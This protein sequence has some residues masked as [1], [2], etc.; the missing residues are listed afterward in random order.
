MT[1][2]KIIGISLLIFL[3]IAAGIF[4]GV[5]AGYMGGLPKLSAYKDLGHDQ[6]SKVYSA[7]GTVIATF[8]AE[9]N[10]EIIPLNEIPKNVQNAVIDMEDERFYKHHGVDLKAIIRA[11]YAN[12]RSREVSE[13]ASTITQQYV[14]NS[15]I[16]P[17]VT[18]SRK[19]K[20]AAL[21]YQLEQKYSKDK[22][23]EMY[24]NTIYFGQGCYGV[25]TASENF[26]HKKAKDL[27]LGESSLLAGL[28]GAPNLFSPYTNPDLTYKRRAEV[29]S[30]LLKNKHITKKEYNASLK[31]P[32][33]VFPINLSETPTIAPY[34][35][36]HVKLTLIDK[37]GANMVYRGGLRIH[38]TIDLRLQGIAEDA[39][40]NTLNEP[41]DP[42][43][44]LA[45]IDPKNGYIKALVGGR[46]FN[47]NKF[48]LATQS[49]RCPGSSFK[50]VALVSA[51]ENNIPPS[52]SY[53][54]S[55]PRYIKL[56]D[57]TWRVENYEGRQ[58]S[59]SMSII[60]A[61]VWSVNVVYAQLAMDVGAGKVA[62]T[63]QKLGVTSNVPPYPAI[64]IGGLPEGVSPLEMASVYATLAND[65]VYMKPIAI[66]KVTDAQGNLIEQAKIEGKAVI[67]KN[68]ART[69]NNILKQV[70]SRGTGS[71]ADIGRPAAGKTGTAEYKQDAWFVG[72]TPDL[73]TAVWMGYPEGSITM[74]YVHGYPPYGG[75]LPAIMWQ[76]FMSAALEG[77][78]P[79][80]FPG[81]EN[82]P[83]G[84]EVM[85]S[86]C[87]E[88]GLLANPACPSTK[89]KWFTAGQEPKDYC[90]I[91]T[92]P[93]QTT[94]PPAD[95]P[96]DGSVS[97]AGVEGQSLGSAT[98]ILTGQGLVVVFSKQT[99]ETVPKDYVISQSPGAGSSAQPG[100]TVTLVVSDGPP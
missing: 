46:D 90:N 62:E 29:L 97:V 52:R 43:G 96:H 7:D 21:A 76:R 12:L 69:A 85:V 87:T 66:T 19:I 65:G 100:S 31:E 9:Q 70:I 55:S 61:T 17:E 51:L 98:S 33:N 82:I 49:K 26:F 83:G 88:S 20:E 84:G 38:T 74:D 63:A 23:L 56:A 80:D 3:V 39:I 25:Q 71:R 32:I 92:Q 42:S 22:I 53:D 2:L 35:V 67:S 94:Q 50:A 24:L 5:A 6:T 27:T 93:A 75:S 47:T 36:E 16:T 95:Q 72:H 28:V 15:L 45:S 64:A 99:S 14:R 77:V 81:A 48:N 60:E 73:A 58:F 40:W 59:G 79:S 89:D 11:V 54:A 30:R 4:A 37:Y 57:E 8:H 86:I 34:F 41:G 78:P 13:G 18:M 44:A 10:R 1:A 91:H 68:V